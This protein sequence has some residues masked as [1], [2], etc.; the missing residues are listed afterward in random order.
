MTAEQEGA[1]RRLRAEGHGVTAVARAT[2]LART[3]VYRILAESGFRPRRR[4][5][6]ARGPATG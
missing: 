6:A 2:G 3:T 1:V 5:E 4:L